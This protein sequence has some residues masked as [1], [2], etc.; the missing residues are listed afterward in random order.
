MKTHGKIQ[1]FGKISENQKHLR[2]KA[3]FQPDTQTT[4]QSIDNNPFTLEKLDR[5]KEEFR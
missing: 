5:K 1:N 2:I 3:I 4:H